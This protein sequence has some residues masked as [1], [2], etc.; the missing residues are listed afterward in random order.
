M[1]GNRVAGIPGRPQANAAE[2]STA[3]DEVCIQH[4]GHGIPE[5]QVRGAHDPVGDT[6]WAIDAGSAHRGDAVD[7]LDLADRAHGFRPVR[8]EH[9]SALDEHGRHDVMAALHIRQDLLQQIARS[10]ACGTEVPQVMVRVTNWQVG[11]EGFL[12]R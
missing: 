6:R 12:D 1:I 9:G 2:P 5:H 11:F 4:R 10:D 3:S 7:E 8:F